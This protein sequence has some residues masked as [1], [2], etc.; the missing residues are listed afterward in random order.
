VRQDLR[1][2]KVKRVA[3]PQLRT[4]VAQQIGG[5]AEFVRSETRHQ[6]VFLREFADPRAG[7]FRQVRRVWP[8][9]TLIAAAEVNSTSDQSAGEG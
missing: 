4:F 8:V 2:G 6:T 5:A 1:D 3:R 9:R 7:L